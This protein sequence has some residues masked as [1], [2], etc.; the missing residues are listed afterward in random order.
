MR[1]QWFSWDFDD[2]HEISMILMRFQ[3]FSWHFNDSHEISKYFIE[4]NEI[5][6]NIMKFSVLTGP[7]LGEPVCSILWVW[8]TKPA[9]SA[10]M[11]LGAI[12][13]QKISMV[14]IRFE[15]FLWDIND[16]HEISMIPMRFQCF[17]WDFNDSHEISMILSDS[18]DGRKMMN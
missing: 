4:Y 16:S 9:R 14:L 5:L 3:W 1:F 11:G 13:S 10:T 12:Y 7:I 8:S 18:G 17:S 6:W 15:G 2:S